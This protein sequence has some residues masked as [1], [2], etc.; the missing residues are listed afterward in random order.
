MSNPE[1]SNESQSP[2]SSL[3]VSLTQI[4]SS[5]LGKLDYLGKELC[6]GGRRC[7]PTVLKKK[8]VTGVA[9]RRV[10]RD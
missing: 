6:L 9:I 3:A 5:H 10:A 1:C 4:L 7:G 2:P 8:I